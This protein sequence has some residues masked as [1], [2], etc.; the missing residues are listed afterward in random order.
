MKAD[1][2]TGKILDMVLEI[3]IKYLAHPAGGKASVN[4][5]FSIF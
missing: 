1:W 5:Y 3:I 4:V 2:D